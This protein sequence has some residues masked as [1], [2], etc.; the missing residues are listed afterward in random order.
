MFTKINITDEEIQAIDYITHPSRMVCPTSI[1]W[2]IENFK[3]K[4]TQSF[5]KEQDD[6]ILQRAKIILKA[7]L[8]S[9]EKKEKKKK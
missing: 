5:G 3:R 4:I 6:A 8:E 2:I 9:E 7:E 1:G